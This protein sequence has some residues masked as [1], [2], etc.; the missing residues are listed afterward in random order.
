MDFFNK[1]LCLAVFLCSMA[2]IASVPGTTQQVLSPE[3]LQEKTMRAKLILDQIKS[4]IAIFRNSNQDII[5]KEGGKIANILNS[6]TKLQ[7][8]IQKIKDANNI[9]GLEAGIE[10]LKAQIQDA[11]VGIFAKAVDPRNHDTNYFYQMYSVLTEIYQRDNFIRDKLKTILDLQGEI[12]NYLQ[13]KMCSIGKCI[14]ALRDLGGKA[15]QATAEDQKAVSQLTAQLLPM[16][17]QLITA[18][19][20]PNAYK[21]LTPKLKDLSNLQNDLNNAIAGLTED[22]RAAIRKN[23]SSAQQLSTIF[24]FIENPNDAATITPDQVMSFGSKITQ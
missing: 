13:D 6:I 11:A 17:S 24:G 16:Q 8:E 2:I 23:N 18:Q 7:A 9:S 4:S 14:P 19:M 10:G 20:Q 5:E 15:A 22:K 21:E 12:S 1:T 3:E